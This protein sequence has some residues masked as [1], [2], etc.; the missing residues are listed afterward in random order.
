MPCT[1]QRLVDLVADR[2][3]G[4]SAACESWNT[5]AMSRPR[6]SRISASAGPEV[7]PPTH[8]A[9]GARPGSGSSRMIDRPSR[10]LPDPLSPTIPRIRPAFGNDTP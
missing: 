5:I 8:R 10:D 3:T 4:L 6:T 7:A 2:R 9:R 1:D